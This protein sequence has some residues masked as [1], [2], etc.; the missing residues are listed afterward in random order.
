[1]PTPGNLCHAAMVRGALP[2]VVDKA[3]G[4][5]FVLLLLCTDLG[6]DSLE[7]VEVADDEAEVTLLEAE[8]R[9]LDLVD[10][11]EAVDDEA[12]LVRLTGG[13]AVVLVVSWG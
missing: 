6:L 5:A 12:E 10:E 8:A 13:D 9:E 1:M 11:R 2:L 4:R 3:R 7:V